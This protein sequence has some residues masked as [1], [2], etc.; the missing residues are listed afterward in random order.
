[1]LKK[2]GGCKKEK[3][4]VVKFFRLRDGAV[5]PSKSRGGDLGWDITCI[6]DPQFKF[7][8]ETG[9]WCFDLLPNQPHLFH[10]GFSTEFSPSFGVLL[11]DRSGLGSKGIHVLA[12]VIDSGY[13]GQWFVGLVNLSVG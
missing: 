9:R 7:D 1:M 4:G 12:G 3:G 5:I 10:T 13:R 2:W 8:K 11:R 6:S